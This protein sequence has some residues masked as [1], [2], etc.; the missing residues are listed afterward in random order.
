MHERATSVY[1][2]ITIHRVYTVVVREFV[3]LRRRHEVCVPDLAAR[4]QLP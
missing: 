1:V 2:R 4:S 3:E